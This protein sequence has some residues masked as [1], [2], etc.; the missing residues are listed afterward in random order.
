[1]FDIDGVLARGTNPLQAA[2]DA[3]KILTDEEGQL[4][5]PVAFVT[6]ACNRSADKAAQ[7]QGWLG[8]EVSKNAN[9]IYKIKLILL[10]LLHLYIYIYIFTHTHTHTYIYINIY[11]CIHTHIYIYTRTSIHINI[12]LCTHTHTY[13]YIHT[14][15]YIYVHTHTMTD[16][17]HS[18]K[19]DETVSSIHISQALENEL[20][21]Y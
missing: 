2:I 8:I 17:H 10:F 18:L 1:M 12:Y 6:N 19:I 21:S 11:I 14:H 15:T 16:I 9:L 3:F 4:R 13:I 20:K 7:I 5:V